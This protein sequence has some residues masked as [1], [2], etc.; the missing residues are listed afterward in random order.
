MPRQSRLD[1]CGCL[2]HLINRGIERRK[3]FND[4]SDYQFFIDCLAQIIGEGGYHC[5]GWVLMPNHFHLMV[6]RGVVPI[7]RL[8]SRL[9]TR[10][11]GYFNR[12]YRRSGRLFQNR[13]KAII[14]DKDSY[15][16][17]LVAYIHL[18]P[19]RANMVKTLNE[20]EGYPW[21]GHRS[22]IGKDIRKWQDYK[23]VLSWFGSKRGY[24]QYLSDKKGVKLDLSGGGLLRSIGGWE[25]VLKRKKKEKERYDTRILG[26]GEF[27]ESLLAEHE[28]ELPLIKRLSFETIMDRVKKAKGYNDTDLIK[29]GK[30]TKRGKE[31]RAIISYLAVQYGKETMQNVGDRFSISGQAISEL[32]KSGEVL[33]EGNEEL[34]K[35]ILNN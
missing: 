35:A 20:L 30:S 32:V 29:P 26:D 7:S 31:G 13:Y 9:C 28:R 5:Y 27:V 14:C 15:A 17:E 6:E 12:K 4:K 18:N 25:E 23:N 10:Y 19:L 33:V 2:Y 16:K 22:L 1:Y 24:L 11:A 21:S 3:I 34:K 8:M